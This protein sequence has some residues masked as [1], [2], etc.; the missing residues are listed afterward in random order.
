MGPIPATERTLPLTTLEREIRD[1]AARH[2]HEF[3]LV[4]ASDGQ[5]WVIE[6][7][8]RRNVAAAV[9]GL[10]IKGVAEPIGLPKPT[11][12]APGEVKQSFRLL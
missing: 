11:G 7:F 12:R 9:K 3:S 1:Y 4:M 2:N 5:V 10:V 8:G 6:E